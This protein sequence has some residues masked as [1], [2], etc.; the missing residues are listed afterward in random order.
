MLGRGLALRGTQAPSSNTHRR[1]PSA[2]HC[3]L[4][5]KPTTAQAQAGS[6][7]D[8]EMRSLG[9]LPGH[10]PRYPQPCSRLALPQAP[11]SASCLHDPQHG[12]VRLPQNFV[13]AQERAEMLPEPQVPS[14]GSCAHMMFS[15]G[16]RASGSSWRVTNRRR[17]SRL[18]DMRHAPGVWESQKSDDTTRGR[19]LSV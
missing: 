4:S 6:H 15:N 16:S 13:Q 18:S 5:T 9:N 17:H 2:K 7:K 19:A 3:T 1:P 14:G 10:V 8:T 12:P 11:P